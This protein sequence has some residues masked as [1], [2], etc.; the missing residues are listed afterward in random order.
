MAL[1][2]VL[3][4]MIEAGRGLTPEPASHHNALLERRHVSSAYRSRAS[5]TSRVPRCRGIPRLPSGIRW[6]RV[7]QKEQTFA[8]TRRV[9]DHER[10][11]ISEGIHCGL[12]GQSGA[13]STKARICPQT[14][15]DRFR[16][17][18]LKRT[19]MQTPRWREDE[20]P[21][22]QSLLGNRKRERRRRCQA[23]N[24]MPRGKTPPCQVDRRTSHRNSHPHVGG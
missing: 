3:V 7:E 12:I 19:P 8:P 9:E 13:E 14:C 1:R 5:R 18:T 10:V 23:R 16:R 20:Q 24:S 22:R 4:K 15:F 11:S 21:S 2:K 17:A 6:Q